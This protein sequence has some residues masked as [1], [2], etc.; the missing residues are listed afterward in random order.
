MQSTPR[1]SLPLIQP[2]QAQKHITHNEALIRLDMM[3]AVSVISDSL[4]EPP[5]NP[6][7]GDSYCVG[8]APTGAWAGLVGQIVMWIGTQW[9]HLPSP[10]GLLMF[11]HDI[12]VWMIRTDVGWEGLNPDAAADLTA[13]SLFVNT[14]ADPQNRVSV[15]TRSMLLSHDDV[16]PD[17]GDVRL[18][19]NKAGMNDTASFL[20]A[21]AYQSRAEIGLVGNDDLSIRVSADGQMFLPAIT[22]SAATGQVSL[23]QGL[24]GPVTLSGEPVGSLPAYDELYLDPTGGNDA[25][26][27]LSAVS[28]VKTVQGLASRFRIGRWLRIFLLG[29]INWDHYVQI[30]YPVHKMTFA[31]VTAAG[32]YTKRKIIV[33][34]ATNVAGYP[35]C[36]AFECHGNIEFVSVDIELASASVYPFLLFNGTTGFMATENMVISRT[37]SGAGH[38]LGIGRCFVPN[39]HTNLTVEAS[40]AGYVA[41]DVPAGGDPN[42]RPNFI[43]NVTSM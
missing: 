18:S 10:E 8:N 32:A 39:F 5:E 34:D 35:G 40:A 28:A 21:N 3:S 14:T 2:G 19:L 38:V 36:L 15:K 16:T 33:Q 11:V 23:P 30:S 22:V 41:Y 37:G 25:N 29:D 20:L 9:N 17:G 26:D 31:G 24:S 1:L 42:A 7:D 4:S 12:G 13:Q 43:S 27:G 6:A